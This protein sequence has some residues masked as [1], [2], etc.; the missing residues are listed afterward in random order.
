M[1]DHSWHSLFKINRMSHQIHDPLSN[2][3]NLST[4]SVII[5]AQN[6]QSKFFN[7][8][9]Q[10]CSTS[11]FQMLPSSISTQYT[12]VMMNQK[13][14]FAS[15]QQKLNRTYQNLLSIGS[16]DF[17]GVTYLSRNQIILKVTNSVHQLISKV[18]YFSRQSGQSGHYL[19]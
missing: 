9:I 15:L 16:V 10:L 4:K 18:N 13:V 2:R 8:F 11:Y 6:C 14:R 3:R 19:I 1:F 7:C 12:V 5:K 17:S